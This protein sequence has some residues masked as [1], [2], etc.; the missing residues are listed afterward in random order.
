[1]TNSGWVGLSAA[2]LSLLPSLRTDDRRLRAPT[3][4]LRIAGGE[5]AATTNRRVDSYCRDAIRFMP[6]A[7]Y[8][9]L[10]CRLTTFSPIRGIRDMCRACRSTR[11]LCE[12]FT[13]ILIVRCAVTG[14]GACAFT[15]TGTVSTEFAASDLAPSG[16]QFVLKRLLKTRARQAVFGSGFTINR[17]HAAFDAMIGYWFDR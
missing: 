11:T 14:T 2:H 9:T 13:T 4:V 10:G 16:F 3:F 12:S 1:M 17:H 5:V 6:D 15:L 8:C 7:R